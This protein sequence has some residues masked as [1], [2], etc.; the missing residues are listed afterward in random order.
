MDPSFISMTRSFMEKLKKFCILEMLD[1]VLRRMAHFNVRL[2]PSK[3]SF[4]MTSVEF[5]SH[6]F[7]KHG[8]HL[9]N[10]RVRG[11]QDIPIPT[12]VSTIR[13]F[14]GMVNYFRDFIPSLSSYLG[15]LT[16][17]TKKK[18]FGDNGFKMTEKQIS[19]FKIVKDQVAS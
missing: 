7:Y 6:I 8:L 14:V 16:D 9:S 11:I 15:P 13:S 19:F 12:S 17:L 18:I 4:G 5:L 2:K 1:M 3:C 10:K